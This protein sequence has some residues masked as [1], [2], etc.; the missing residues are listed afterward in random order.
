M[1]AHIGSRIRATGATAAVALLA[2][3]CGGSNTPVAGGPPKIGVVL[4]YNLPG[5]WGNYL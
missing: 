5:F 2:V 3:A 1:R 4:T